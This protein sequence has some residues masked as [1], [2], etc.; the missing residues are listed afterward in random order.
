[1]LNFFPT[2]AMQNS[3]AKNQPVSFPHDNMHTWLG[4]NYPCSIVPVPQIFIL[5]KIKI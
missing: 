5:P 3:C 4:V 1:M 2:S